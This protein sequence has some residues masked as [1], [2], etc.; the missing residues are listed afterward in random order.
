MRRKKKC[1]HAKVNLLNFSRHESVF[2]IYKGPDGGAFL[3]LSDG[4]MV[5]FQS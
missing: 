5:L 3:L 4:F 2:A 1:A